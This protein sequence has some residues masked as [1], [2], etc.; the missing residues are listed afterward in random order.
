MA[1]FANWP[2]DRDWERR[3]GGAEQ[4]AIASSNSNKSPI[5][6]GGY[7]RLDF[8]RGEF[9]VSSHIHPTPPATG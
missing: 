8:Y 3:V 9:N 5:P 7:P 1:S 4:F 2:A 6:C